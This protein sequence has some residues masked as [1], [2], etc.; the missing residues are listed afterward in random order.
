M[1]RSAMVAPH[2]W[3]TEIFP[4]NAHP[5]E[6]VGAMFRNSTPSSLKAMTMANRSDVWSSGGHL[7]ICF[8]TFCQ[9]TRD[10][11]Q[12]SRCGKRCLKTTWLS[13]HSEL[14]WERLVYARWPKAKENKPMCCMGEEGLW[15]VFANINWTRTCWVFTSP[16]CWFLFL[17]TIQSPCVDFQSL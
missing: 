5:Q 7:C 8:R 12:T 4:C 13:V 14:R 10:P 11:W 2:S 9:H 16:V 17:R 6:S 3:K 1:R 15:K